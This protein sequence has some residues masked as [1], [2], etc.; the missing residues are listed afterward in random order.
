[1]EKT[2]LRKNEFR[3]NETK[4]PKLKK[5]NFEIE[6][7]LFEKIKLERQENFISQKKLV[8]ELLRL[9]FK[10]YQTNKFNI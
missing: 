1:M 5:T 6:E 8:N 4:N 10:T 3:E 2:T 9:G 7:I